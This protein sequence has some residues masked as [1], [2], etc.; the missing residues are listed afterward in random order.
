[1]IKG[2]DWKLNTSFHEIYKRTDEGF[3]RL[4]QKTGY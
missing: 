1:M 2:T 4:V 3:K